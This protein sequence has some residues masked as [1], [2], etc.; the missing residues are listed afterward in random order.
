MTTP[1]TI[2]TGSSG[3]DV[4]LA[5]YELCRGLFLSGPQDVDGAFG[6]RT[7]QAV[8]EYQQQ[9]GLGVD[10]VV[11]PHT[12]AAMLAEHPVPPTLAVGTAGAV[13]ARLQQFLN[14][15]NPAATPQLNVDESFGPLTASAVKA[16]QSA[17]QVPANGIVD[18]K[19][20]V[21]HIGGANAMVASSVDV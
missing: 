1:S 15:A 14:I 20:W 18:D 7:T 5:Q 2:K 3:P 10:G 16:Y 4:D 9:S 8:R 13:V 21:I 17:H 19:T 12:W 11:G 6:P